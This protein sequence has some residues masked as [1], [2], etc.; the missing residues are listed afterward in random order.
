MAGQGAV[1]LM[2]LVLKAFTVATGAAKY[3]YNHVKVWPDPPRIE[4]NFPP[5]NITLYSPAFLDTDQ[6]PLAFANGTEGPTSDAVLDDFLTE[7]ASRNSW[8]NYGSTG[9]VTEEGRSL[10]YVYLSTS[11]K[12]WNSTLQVPETPMPPSKTK[13]RVWLQGGVHGSEPAG[14]QCILALLGKMDA[15]PHWTASLLENLDIM[16]LPRYNP[17]GIAYFQR[18][19]ASNFDPNRDHVKL[20][21]KQT[22]SI[23]GMFS[24][25]D[26]HVAA[27]MH[28]FRASAMYGGKYLP[29]ADAMFSAAKNLNIHPEIRRLSESL[30]APAI[31]SRLESRG[32][33]WEPYVTGKTSLKPSTPITFHEAGTDAKIGRNA[34]GLS[35]AIVFLCEV[36]GIGIADQEFARRTATAL[37]ILESIVETASEHAHEILRIVDDSVREFVNGDNDIVITDFGD[38]SFRNWTFLDFETGDL[39]QV[40]VEFCSTT[41]SSANLTRSKPEAYLIPLPWAEI[42]SRLEILGL[43][44]QTLP[45]SWSGTVEAL[46]ITSTSLGRAY[47]DGAVRA[48]VST[49]TTLTDIRLPAGSFRVRTRQKNAAL[50][51]VTLEPEHADSYVSTGIIPLEKGDQYPIFRVLR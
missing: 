3:G 44:V 27:D 15:E 38:K 49:N 17:D 40:P 5:P 8:M 23:K 11:N 39:M 12:P 48:N 9:D 19:F 34:M 51:F 20:A 35:Q 26:P 10:R 28:E 41:P 45:Q 16:L 32:F 43:E 1:K 24:Q 18:D 2:L 14:D 13:L 22:R 21:R 6:I 36:R 29:G 25:F 47:D 37:T 42:A 31:S 30:F 33:R 4:R 7:I 50:A 46:K